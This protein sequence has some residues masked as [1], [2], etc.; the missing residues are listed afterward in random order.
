MENDSGGVDDFAEREAESPTQFAIHGVE[1]AFNRETG[2]SIVQI[3]G[4]DF[5]TNA[6]ENGADRV[7]GSNAALAIEQ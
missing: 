6:L 5:L 4:V 2:S 3:A 1:Y 7:A